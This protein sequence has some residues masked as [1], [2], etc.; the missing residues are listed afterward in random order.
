MSIEGVPSIR[1]GRVDRWTIHSSGRVTIL[2]PGEPWHRTIMPLELVRRVCTPT[3]R[4]FG[5]TS[6][7]VSWVY[8]APT[9]QAS[10]EGHSRVL[11]PTVVDEL[12]TWYAGVLHRAA[13]HG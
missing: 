6:L 3:A 1:E 10:G 2:A 13:F 12:C 4:V 8:P 11:P 5:A 7:V 9:M